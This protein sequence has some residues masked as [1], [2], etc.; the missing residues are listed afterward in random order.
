MLFSQEVCFFFEPGS[1]PCDT[2]LIRAILTFCTQPCSRFSSQA[3]DQTTGG[4]GAFDLFNPTEEHRQLRDMVRS[5]VE[6]EVDPQALEF[7]RKEEVR[8]M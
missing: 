1:R 2:S 3:A 8:L 7:N 4:Q 6:K 5:F